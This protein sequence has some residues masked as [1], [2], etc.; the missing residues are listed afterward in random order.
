VVTA[1][2]G[3]TSTP[4]DGLTADVVVVNDFDELQ[5]LGHDEVAG[6]IVLFNEKFDVQKAWAG[7]W[8]EAYDEA[9]QY[10]ASGAKAAAAL[11]A[12]AS[13]A[14]SVGGADYRLPHTGYSA[15]AGIRPA[16]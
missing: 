13:L 5:A 16:P 7:H 12:V 6:K 10:R 9:V 15:P 11:G 2:G 4:A 8:D 3:S 1:L 14:R